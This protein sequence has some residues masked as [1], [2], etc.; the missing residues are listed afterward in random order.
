MCAMSTV[1]KPRFKNFTKSSMSDIPVTISAFNSGMLV[2]P[3]I[4][5]VPRFFIALMPM[6]ASVPI[7]VESTAAQS[8]ICSVMI[9]AFMIV[10]SVKQEAYHFKVNPPHTTLDLELLKERTTKTKIGRYKNKK[11]T[12]R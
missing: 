10:L 1:T 2:A 9:S 3:S 8:V 7:S 12:A 6:A 5:V 4:S 11:M